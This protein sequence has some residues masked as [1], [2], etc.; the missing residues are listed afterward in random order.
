MVKNPL[1]GTILDPRGAA[2]YLNYKIRSEKEKG[3]SFL[4]AINAIWTLT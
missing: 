3:T 1:K 2:G 4:S